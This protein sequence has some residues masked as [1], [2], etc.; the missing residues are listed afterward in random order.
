MA[1]KFSL[2][3]VSL[4]AAAV[5]AAPAPLAFRT[6][7]AKPVSET[8]KLSLVPVSNTNRIISVGR[9]ISPE[10]NLSLAWQT[11][12]MAS[13]VAVTLGMQHPAVVLE[14]ISDVTAVDCTGNASVSVTFN[15]TDAYNEALSSWSGLN[16]SFVLVTNHL[17]DCDAEIERS[18]FVA[19]TDTLASYEGN[20]TIIAKAEKKDVYSTA[21]K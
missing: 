17:G 5:Y 21:S 2:G 19:D 18:F 8:P 3:L 20:L 12:D 6:E 11:P 10:K 7:H 16:D 14:D 15:N 9:N 4:L 1:V 13:L